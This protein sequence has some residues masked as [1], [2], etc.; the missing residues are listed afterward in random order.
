MSTALNKSGGKK[1]LRYQSL[2]DSLQKAN[3]DIVHRILPDIDLDAKVLGDSSLVI[4]CHLSNQLEECRHLDLFP[5]F[6]RFAA[7]VEFIHIL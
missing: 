1:R 7:Y 4:K 6:R 3:V 2:S 5:S